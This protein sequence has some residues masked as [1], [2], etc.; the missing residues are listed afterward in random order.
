MKARSSHN[1]SIKVGTLVAAMVLAA[2][3]MLGG[4][5]AAMSQEPKPAIAPAPAQESPRSSPP[6]TTPYVRPVIP[7]DTMNTPLPRPGGANTPLPS[8][9]DSGATVPEPQSSGEAAPLGAGENPARQP[10]LR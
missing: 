8:P 2:A 5:R 3:D 10:S 4:M 9:K 6:D 1:A 7:E